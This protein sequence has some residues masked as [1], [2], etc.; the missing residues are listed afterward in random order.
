MNSLTVALIS[1]SALGL[2]YLW[3]GR[4]L[5]RH[6]EIDKSRPTPGQKY[7]DGIDY[8]CAK[9]WFVLFGHHF[10]SIAG[11]GPILGPVIAAIAWGWFPV[12][13]W[14]VLGSILLGGVHDFSALMASVK[15]QG[16]SIAEVSEKVGTPH[17]RLLFAWFIFLTLILVVAVF[18]AVAANTLVSKPEL[19]IPT[20]ALIGIAIL[21]GFLVYRWRWNL[22]IATIIGLILVALSL[23]AGFRW[24]LAFNLPVSGQQIIWIL[25][26]MAYAYIA[27]VIPV[28]ILLQPRDY[29]SCFILF[30]GLITGVIGLFLTHPQMHAP[31]FITWHAHSGP[32]WPMLM[33]TVAC[34]A[35]SG[36][37]SLVAS[38][39]TSK[40]LPNEGDA[41][42]IGYGGM[43]MEGVLAILALVSVCAGLAWT[44]GQGIPVYSELMK[45]G[46]W[47]VT[48]AEGFGQITKPLFGAA[49]AA[50]AAVM[51]NSFVLTTL[52]T[53]TRI[54]RYILEEISLSWR[55]IQRP[56]Q[57]AQKNPAESKKWSGGATTINLYIST[58]IVVGLS[59]LLALGN[60]SLI[61]PVFGAANQQVAALALITVSLV[62]LN[63][64]K[65]AW[66]TIYPAI[67][68]L[69][70][71][72]G[73]LIYQGI[74]FFKANNW[75]L[76]II[77]LVL[78]FLALFVCIEAINVAKRKKTA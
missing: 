49:G 31:A 38:G 58:T 21:V 39:T 18:A 40:Q 19:V 69:A 72:L 3:Y 8:V 54:N 75:L 67:F 6:W 41:L 52:D 77:S 27:S 1:F 11:A 33:V 4:F 25:I 12:A 20:F 73:A 68:M 56:H 57:R 59:L 9:N 36:F 37:H 28:N 7:H 2:G 44:R 5:K 78:L 17:L 10:A 74:G 16:R 47:I 35:I 61:W 71:T 14:I 15:Y 63:M 23:L 65:S 60:W 48:F 43:I 66:I 45:D 55:F 30:F 34:G 32:L 13:I 53:A 62:L 51:L 46:G 76:G 50:V 26:L 70:T 22:A 64:G 42:K 29:I 24:P